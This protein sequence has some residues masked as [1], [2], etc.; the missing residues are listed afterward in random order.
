MTEAAHAQGSAYA[1]GDSLTDNG[2]LSRFLLGGA[3]PNGF[4]SADGYVG[5]GF[6]NGQTWIEYLPGIT[7][8]SFEQGNDFAFGGGTSGA[9]GLPIPIGGGAFF[10]PPTGGLTQTE[11]FKAAQTQLSPNDYVG[12]WLGTNDIHPVAGTNGGVTNP[13]TIDSLAQATADTAAE[14]IKTSLNSIRDIGAKNFIL[15]N[16]YDMA[17]I[18]P[19]PTYSSYNTALATSATD[20]LNQQLAT[21]EIEGANIHY[22]DVNSLVKR[23]IA[24]PVK[25]G[26]TSVS[27]FNSC[28]DNACGS[29][30]REQQNQFLFMDTIHF[31]TGFQQLLGE[32]AAN[33]ITAGGVTTLQ[34]ESGLGSV[35]TTQKNAMYRIGAD[36]AKTTGGKVQ[37]FV[38]PGVDVSEQV[39]S[40]ITSNSAS[41]DLT[42]LSVGASYRVS[43]KIHV[44]AVG[45]YTKSETDLSRKFGSNDFDYGQV[46]VFVAFRDHNLSADVG[47]TGTRGSFDLIRTGVM[48]DLSANPDA[49]A[50]GAFAQVKYLFDT[51]G[52]NVRFGPIASVS[53][54]K[55]NV[56]GYT[57]SGDS[58]ITISTEDQ[59]LDQLTANFGVTL[60][61]KDVFS[62]GLDFQ[63]Q[64]TGEYQKTGNHDLGY[65]QTNAPTRRL[66]KL[67][68]SDSELYGRVSGSVNYTYTEGQT[69]FVTG[70][71][72]FGRDEGEQA[73]VSAGLKINY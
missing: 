55:L 45:N 59:S 67:I 54:T 65:Y 46:G 17:L 56:D 71:T 7:G 60:L 34:T 2:G 43:D 64:L 58:L 57:E 33:L 50:F 25:F 53:Y 13:D 40:D 62:K 68:D 73:G 41:S 4:S 32:Y 23:I 30:S 15:L 3:D 24:D 20:K 37:W 11:L 42:S 9:N 63:I 39:L 66:S 36:L 29:L 72:T 61:G 14:N 5:G 18:D 26:Y 47:V 51:K 70:T 44:G 31:T 52:S 6:S 16:V 48:D 49:D 10:I 35:S 8:L 22:L 38:T 21:L 69:L 19:A 28:Q 12:V 1:I 27:A